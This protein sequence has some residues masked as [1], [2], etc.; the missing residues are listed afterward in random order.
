MVSLYR[1]ARRWVARYR[2]GRSVDVW[3]HPEYAPKALAETARGSSIDVDRGR[4]IVTALYRHGLVAPCRIKKPPAATT[5]DLLRFHPMSYLETTNDAASVARVFGFEPS[6]VDAE[7]VVRAS[8]RATGGTIAAARSVV[9][10]RGKVA[11]NLGGGF[12]HAQADMGTGFCIHNDVAVAI[13][14]LREEGFRGRVLIIDLDFHQGDGFIESFENDPGVLV[15]SI[16]GSIWSHAESRHHQIHLEGRVADRKYLATLRQT[17]PATLETHQPDLIFYVAG[18]DVLAGDAF[19][20]FSLTMQGVF[21]RDRFVVDGARRRGVPLVVTMA[22]GYSRDAWRA[23]FAMIRYALT[24]DSALA[25]TAQPSLKDRF[26]K[27]ASELDPR[28]LQQESDS[29]DEFRITEAD[30][31]GALFG[32][33]TAD[34]LLDFYTQH[35]VELAFERYG[36]FE[37]LRARGFEN[38]TLTIDAADRSHQVLRVYGARRASPEVMLVELVVRRK[39]IPDPAAPKKRIEVLSV[40]WLMMQDPTRDFTLSRMPLPGQAHPGLGVSAEMRQMLVQVVLRLNLHGWV[41]RP[42]YYHTALGVTG[43]R[44]L[45]PKEEGQFRALQIRLGLP[46]DDASWAIDEGRVRWGDGRPVEWR[47]GLRVLAVS[48]PLKEWFSG[49][50]YLEAVEQA[51]DAAERRGVHVDLTK[52]GVHTARVD[53]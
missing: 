7:A 17:L 40:E 19:G 37:S 33:P 39:W 10:T 45:D 44:F 15:Y 42:A 51:Q 26:A 29:D 2:L 47:P 12:H 25:P 8:L 41:N 20:T 1:W 24:D 14:T 31:T 52:A 50:E 4:R 18:N 53:P 9:A 30:I 13:A 6:H 21:E 28:E 48:E 35:G 43:A 5:R 36:L 3:Y 46:F 16:H 22:G 49:P 27:V 34:R 11:F 23:T 38:P 32:P